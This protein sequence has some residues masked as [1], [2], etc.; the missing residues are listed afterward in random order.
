MTDDR[1]QRIRERAHAI[2]EQEGRPDMR[3]EEH[4]HQAR[5]EI[6]DTSEPHG[7]SGDATDGEHSPLEDG[8]LPKEDLM[9]TAALLGRN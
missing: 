9:A 8:I 3:H 7:Q 2:W 5:R 4:W 1:E 6:G